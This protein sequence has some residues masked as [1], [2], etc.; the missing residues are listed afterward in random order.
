MAQHIYTSTIH[1]Y[2]FLLNPRNIF[3]SCV[4][5]TE[6]YFVVEAF[7][8]AFE[9]VLLTQIFHSCS[10][11]HSSLLFQPTR[12]SLGS[13]ALVTNGNETDLQALLH[14]KAKMVIRL[15][16]C[17]RGTTAS[18]FANGIGLNAGK[19]NISQNQFSGPF[20]FSITNASNLMVLQVYG[21]KFTE[22]VPSFGNLKQL[23][24]VIIS[25]NLLGTH[26]AN[27]LSF[28]CSSTNTT[29]LELVDLSVNNFGGY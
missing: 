12:S 21:D 1:I 20:P 14:F 16:F 6:F 13:A 27:D 28:V 15:G 26:R 29:S 2:E 22:K 3:K 9:G 7:Q 10:C 19:N 5:I 18:I 8:N 17:V 4:V 11:H 24:I 23:Q 25:E